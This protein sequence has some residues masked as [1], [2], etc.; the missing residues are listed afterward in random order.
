MAE[1]WAISKPVQAVQLSWATWATV[2]DICGENTLKGTMLNQDNELGEYPTIVVDIE[3][4]A[5]FLEARTGD[6]IVRSESGL[7]VY[8]DKTFRDRYEQRK[9]NDILEDETIDVGLRW[10]KRIQ[11]EVKNLNEIY[12]VK[13]VRVSA[14]IWL[15]IKDHLIE[16]NRLPFPHH[17]T[18]VETGYPTETYA[19]MGDSFIELDYYS[20]TSNK[21]LGT[22][23]FLV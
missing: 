9:T 19:V 10:I 20:K 14:G 7:W 15:K 6:W 8:D 11:D 16:D 17:S 12:D 3:T 2:C 13:R 21:K 4:A 22:R 1:Y 18:A 5:G 23:G